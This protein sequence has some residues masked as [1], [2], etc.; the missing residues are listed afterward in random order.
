[1]SREYNTPLKWLETIL[2]DKEKYTWGAAIAERLE[3][4]VEA[5]DESV[6]WQEKL[7]DAV[8]LLTEA[9]KVAGLPHGNSRV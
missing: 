2:P 1:M 9:V 5:N 6:K 3:A 7:V 4:L 8:S